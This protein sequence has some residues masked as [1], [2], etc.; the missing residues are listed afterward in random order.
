MTEARA[1]K[2]QGIADDVPEQAVDQGEPGG[3]N[4]PGRCGMSACAGRILV[5]G[6]ALVSAALVAGSATAQALT[7]P[8]EI[9][10]R[11]NLA[12]YYAGADGR[13]DARKALRQHFEVDKRYIVITALNALAEDGA[14]DRKTVAEAIEKYGIDP[15]R[16]DPVTL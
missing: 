5:V 7:D 4:E 6:L 16:P 1:A 11:A 15:D 9:V 3:G 13:S 12:S 10:H 2:I 8:D 14:L